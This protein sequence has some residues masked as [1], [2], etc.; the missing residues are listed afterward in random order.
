M[1]E[2][3]DLAQMPTGETPSAESP[4]VA[5]DYGKLDEL[6]K[7]GQ[8]QAADLETKAIMLRIVGRED[9]LPREIIDEFPCEPLDIV[10]QL[11]LHRS[12]NRF[13]FSVQVRILQEVAGN[14]EKFGDLVGW[15]VN[16]VWLTKYDRRY[17]LQ[18]PTGHLPCA[19][20]RLGGHGGKARSRLLQRF[21]ACELSEF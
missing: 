3:I 10:D 15:R 4:V 2:T 6:L 11:W 17:N 7:T 12:G 13:G 9:Y 5:I 18:A 16:Q 19:A 14:W 1:S 21:V 8:W 20:L